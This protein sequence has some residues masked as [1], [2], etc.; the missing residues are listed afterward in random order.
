MQVEYSLELRFILV[1]SGI[2]MA[3]LPSPR[4]LPFSLRF[5]SRRHRVPW[6]QLKRINP[7][8]QPFFDFLKHKG[9]RLSFMIAKKF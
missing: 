8:H 6:H 1:Q 9:Q 3:N 4:Q 7:I 5:R 2:S